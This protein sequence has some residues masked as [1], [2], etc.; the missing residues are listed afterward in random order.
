MKIVAAILLILGQVLTG[1]SET[2]E[3]VFEVDRDGDGKPDVRVVNVY[4]GE[5]VV[6]R[7]VALKKDSYWR[8]SRFFFSNKQS[9]MIEVDEKGDG[10]FEMFIVYCGDDKYSQGFIREQDRVVPMTE[11]QMKEIHAAQ[12]HFTAFWDKLLSK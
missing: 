3:K 5:T 11:S 4:S 1:C 2:R 6:M 10:F 8:T 12:T 9:V 7:T